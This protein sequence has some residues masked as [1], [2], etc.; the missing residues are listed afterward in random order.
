VNEGHVSLEN[1]EE[2][3][4]NLRKQ[5]LSLKEI[6]RATGSNIS[7]VQRVVKDVP[8]ATG[9]YRKELRAALV[10]GAIINL[11]TTGLDS[12]TDD[13][14][15]FGFLERNIMTVVQRVEANRAEFYDIIRGKL[16][17]LAQPIY[18]YDARF[19][20]AFL[21]AKLHVPVELVDISQPWQH[22]ARTEGRRYPSLDELASVSRQYFGEIVVPDRQVRLLW[23]SYLKTGDKRKFTP[24][25]RHCM[26]DLRQALYILTF[27]EST[28]EGGL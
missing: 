15:A 4:R 20:E 28:V 6:A 12:D 18:A 5:G 25:V 9:L 3:M 23:V 19:H 11:E 17:D 26:E 27:M 1:V 21:L 24:I 16:S 22:G 8:M 14:I 13:I 10:E 7:K 2:Q